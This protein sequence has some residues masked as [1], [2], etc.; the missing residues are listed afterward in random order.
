MFKIKHAKVELQRIIFYPLG[1]LKEIAVYFSL[2]ITVPL[3]IVFWAIVVDLGTNGIEYLFYVISAIYSILLLLYII[4]RIKIVVDKDSGSV[5]Y[6]LFGIK[7]SIASASD[8]CDLGISTH[9]TLKGAQYYC[10]VRHGNN[11]KLLKLTQEINIPNKNVEEAYDNLQKFV[12][13]HSGKNYTNTDRCL[14]FKEIEPNVYL[15]KYR[16]YGRVSGFFVMGFILFF[17]ASLFINKYIFLLYIVALILF[18]PKSNKIMIDLNNRRMN[19]TTDEGRVENTI[20]IDKIRD[21]DTIGLKNMKGFHLSS[22]YYISL[23]DSTIVKIVD[24]PINDNGAILHDIQ[25]LL[26][27]KIKSI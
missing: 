4:G 18:Y 15:C 23:Y 3:L 20:D 12:S 16:M 27:K 17:A 11:I 7:R 9:P 1:N 6:E 13:S 25:L 21:I 2:F 24:K 5:Y 10:H 14:L 8:I 19:V 26:S 22:D